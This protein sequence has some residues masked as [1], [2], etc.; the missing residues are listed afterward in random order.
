MSLQKV[1]FEYVKSA[2]ISLW[3]TPCNHKIKS[4]GYDSARLLYNGVPEIETCTSADDDEE[5]QA[6]EVEDQEFE[7]DFE[8]EDDDDSE[9]DDD[10]EE[11]MHVFLRRPERWSSDTADSLLKAFTYR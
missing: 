6:P 3:I 9:I 8:L 1:S 11:E 7:E 5:N 2:A 10:E 4:Q